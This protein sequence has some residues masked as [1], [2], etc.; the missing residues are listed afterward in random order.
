MLLLASVVSVLF[1]DTTAVA[2]NETKQLSLLEQ[3]VWSENNNSF[4]LSLSIKHL[5]EGDLIEIYTLEE[6]NRNSL[7]ESFISKNS[8][9]TEN[10]FQITLT[11]EQIIK[12][13]ITV[14][15]NTNSPTNN[16]VFSE[17]GTVRPLIV[18]SYTS[19][20]KNSETLVFPL[21]H[22]P[23]TEKLNTISLAFI[24]EINA[25]P[26]LQHDGTYIIDRETITQLTNLVETLKNNPEIK[27]T[28]SLPPA[29]LSSLSQS[30]N[31]KDELLL[32]DIKNLAETQLHIISSPFVTSDPEAWRLI[33]R[34]E[35]YNDLLNRGDRQLTNQLQIEPDRSFSFVAN[36]AVIET[37]DA[38][39]KVGIKTFV[40]EF[41]HIDPT[42][43]NK[44]DPFISL[45]GDNGKVFKVFILD[46]TINFYL[47]KLENKNSDMQFLLGDLSLIAMD[48]NKKEKNLIV[49]IP[50]D[51]SGNLL[52]Q[53]LTTLQN[54]PKINIKALPNLV[55]HAEKNQK[56]DKTKYVLW[57]KSPQDI[58][59]RAPN[60]NLAKA[61]IR[62]YS[63]VIGKPHPNTSFLYELLDTTSASE[64]NE[65]D[66][67]KYF[68]T[69]Y[70]E[71]VKV[72]DGF[73]SPEN[74]NVRLT[75]RKAEL[76]FTLQNNLNHDANVVL[77]LQSDGRI[78]FPAGQTLEVKLNP[79]TNKIKIP[80]S[81]RA[82][83]DSQIRIG[84]RSPDK[85]HLLQLDSNS[86]L[87]RTTRLSG[88][89]ILLF[90]SA[91][92]FLAFWW[93]RSRRLR[94]I[95]RQEEI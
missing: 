56:V 35:T 79:G 31:P 50:N 23:K 34:F 88:V 19:D 48:E 85:E 75:S 55:D 63:E 30:K 6:L 17:P 10:S 54:F 59:T 11:Q 78:S 86:L 84:V 15:L 13:E 72:I 89:G 3:P 73:T 64:L 1:S 83:G 61:A 60:Q 45:Q 74:Q 92:F 76:P 39:N 95:Y 12:K 77:M 58:S 57:N 27:I 70:E 42:P 51:L 9:P 43:E 4:K 32:L 80:V 65:N 67:S 94:S 16:S 41:S 20:Q 7:K 52:N 46:D 68:T 33:D 47:N 49:K 82:S 62:A 37:L 40:T 81:S 24:F 44:I 71:I 90:V 69:I 91:V 29:T 53:F 26:P 22:L 93:L 28:I 5:D 18:K 25:K 36:S 2:Q 14:E 87:I 8:E 21:I 38:L 66:T